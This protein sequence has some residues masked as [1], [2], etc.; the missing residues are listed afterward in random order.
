VSRNDV[1]AVVIRGDL[2]GLGVV[3]S[4]SVGQVPTIL[5]DTERRAAHWSRFAKTVFVDDLHG[6]GLIAG[7]RALRSQLS[8]SPVLFITDEMA[9]TTI[10]ER[11]EELA[12]VC[13]LRLPP[14]ETVTN[15]MNKARLH[16]FVEAH[17]LPAPRTI[18]ISRG[19]D[20]ER[21][22][23]LAF[24]QVAKPADK[25]SVYFGQAE[26]TS[27]LTNL[28]EAE[29]RCAELLESSGEIIVQE[30][31]E[32]ADSCIHFCLFHR[33][34]AD[35]VTMF[36]GRKL[37]AYPPG[38]GTT[39]L[40]AAAPAARDELEALTRSLLDHA[41]YEGMGSVEYKW[42]AR[43]NRFVII[44]PTVGRTDW[45]EEIATLCGVNLPLAAYRDELGLAPLEPRAPRTDVVWQSSFIERLNG[46]RAVLPAGAIVHDGYW[47][48][49]DPLPA[50]FHYPTSLVGAAWRRA[51]ILSLGGLTKRGSATELPPLRKRRRW[52][53]GVAQ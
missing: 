47:R 36:T 20:L 50:L 12:S 40:C 31:V 33:G 26:R 8:H 46:A 41:N 28:R 27:L 19:A 15:F 14:K 39:A 3:R 24:P 51:P 17:N 4:L 43:S 2:N 6:A 5:V 32:G 37:A 44:E 23:S 48:R 22:A 7:L 45:Q 29:A 35:S 49:N 11:R 21:L 1:P 52:S 38:F 53:K 16:E 42:D 10:S 34:R 13:R 9:V 25:S 30:F 18:V